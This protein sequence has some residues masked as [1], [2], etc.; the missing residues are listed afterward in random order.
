MAILKGKTKSADTKA[1]TAAP[2]K[3]VNG[4]LEQRAWAS[5]ILLQPLVTEKA[6]SNG[7]YY[8]K[9]NPTTNRNEVKKAFQ[10]IYG[11]P[12]VKVNMM[13]K[14]GKK[15][16]TGVV[17]GQRGNWKKAIVY[18]AKGETIDLFLS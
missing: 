13:N 7:V 10:L 6:S 18:I 1:K 17:K 3:P 12:A 4:T 15:V 9:V 8:F 2:K 11:K 16:R 14:I 5:K